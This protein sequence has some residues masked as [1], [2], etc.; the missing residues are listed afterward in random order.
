MDQNSPPD[1]RPD[2]LA[3]QTNTIHAGWEFETIQI[4]T[5]LQWLKGPN[6]HITMFFQTLM[7]DPIVNNTDNLSRVSMPSI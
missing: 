2:S 6:A 5:R 4:F 7:L 1:K 3:M